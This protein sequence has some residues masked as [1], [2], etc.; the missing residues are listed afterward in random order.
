MARKKRTTKPLVVFTI[1]FHELSKI[2]KV[3]EGTIAARYHRIKRKHPRCAVML[4]ALRESH[5]TA[6]YRGR[7]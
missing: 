5:K 7:Y 1:S 2:I 3:P 4:S 6:K